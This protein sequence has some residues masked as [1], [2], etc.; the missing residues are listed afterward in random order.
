MGNEEGDVGDE[1]VEYPPA[2]L[3]FC[4]DA[5]EEIVVA[6]SRVTIG[7]CNVSGNDIV[8]FCLDCGLDLSVVMGATEEDEGRTSVSS[9]NDLCDNEGLFCCFDCECP[10]PSA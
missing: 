6:E 8:V 9:V 7:G 10:I 4:V 5:S 1:C 3:T 2:R